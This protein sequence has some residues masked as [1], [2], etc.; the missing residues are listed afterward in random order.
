MDTK[1]LV[2][3]CITG[4]RGAWDI[5]IHAHY[6]LV[7]RSVRYKSRKLGLSLSKEDVL[8]IVQEI[9]MTIWENN[10]LKSLRDSSDLENWLV[11][12]SINFTSNYSQRKLAHIGATVPLGEDISEKSDDSAIRPF[13]PLSKQNIPDEFHMKEL[14]KRLEGGIALL[15]HKQKLALKFNI[16]DGKKQKEIADIMDIP[17]KTV[18]TLIS[19]AKKRLREH[20]G[21]L[22]DEK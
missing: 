19:R 20:L 1:E 21:Q 5:F 2:E 7:I 15:G 10:K 3:K 22:S 6:R 9:F 8:D 4:N 16:Y 17:V 12:V 18:A 11:I 13:I 14:I